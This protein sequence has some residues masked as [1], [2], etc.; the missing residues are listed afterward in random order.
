MH[1]LDI[2]YQQAIHEC[3]LVVKTEEA[4]RLKVRSMVLRDET[5]GVKDQLAQS[6]LRVKELVEQIEDVRSQLDSAQEKSRRQD[7]L[8]QSQAREITNLKVNLTA[9]PAPG[10]SPNLCRNRRNSLLSTL[11]H[12]TQ[13]R[14]CPK[15][16]PSPGKSLFSNPN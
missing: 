9:R 16:S 11:Y 8:M 12:K 1:N 6:N 10:T 13:P 4:R 7:N 14:S 2:K 5:T 15:S 3:D